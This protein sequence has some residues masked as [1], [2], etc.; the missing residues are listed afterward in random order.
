M[1]SYHDHLALLD[2]VAPLYLVHSLPIFRDKLHKSKRIVLI[3]KCYIEIELNFLKEI[4]SGWSL[5]TRHS[6]KTC[7]NQYDISND[8]YYLYIYKIFALNFVKRLHKSPGLEMLK[9]VTS[10]D[11]TTETRSSKIGNY[12][13]KNTQLYRMSIMLSLER[14]QK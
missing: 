5:E 13:F 10:S 2:V 12:W 3:P 8:T 11:V 6:C 7:F 14:H 4:T 9:N 1:L